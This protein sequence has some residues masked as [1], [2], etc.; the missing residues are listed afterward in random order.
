MRRISQN[1]TLSHVGPGS[2]F[3]VGAVA[4]FLG[5]AI[6]GLLWVGLQYVILSGSRSSYYG[7]RTISV[8]PGTLCLSYFILLVV[9]AIGGG[10][11]GAIYAWVYNIAAGWVGGLE[12]TL[13][14]V[15]YISEEPSGES[16]MREKRK[17]SDA[18]PL[19][20]STSRKECPHCGHLNLSWR[21]CENCGK[22]L[23]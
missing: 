4:G 22:L 1:V 2:A 5:W 8:D 23:D 20:Q 12:F 6:F 9:S 3:K 15:G 21:T 17:R 13:D 16:G 14:G 19:S 11:G 18:V 7:Y 10:I